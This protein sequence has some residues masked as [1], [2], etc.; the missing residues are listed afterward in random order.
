MNEIF[1]I[2]MIFQALKAF[3]F[4]NLPGKKATGYLR[5]LTSAFYE[6]SEPELPIQKGAALMSRDFRSELFFC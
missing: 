2:N 5:E 4:K 3:P 6:K 1:L